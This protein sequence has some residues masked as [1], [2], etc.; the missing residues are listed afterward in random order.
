MLDDGSGRI[1]VTILHRLRT[2]ASGSRIRG[3]DGQLVFDSADANP[4]GVG[5]AVALVCGGVRKAT[6]DVTVTPPATAES[7]VDRRIARR[8]PGI[9]RSMQGE[10]AAPGGRTD[11]AG[12]VVQ[13]IAPGAEAAHRA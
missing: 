7:G 1:D 11:P 3:F 4:S 13:L 2:E 6:N 10:A 12:P 8:G 5:G 9:N